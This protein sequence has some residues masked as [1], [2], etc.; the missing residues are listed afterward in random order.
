VQ[1]GQSGSPLAKSSR[2]IMVTSLHG[3]IGEQTHPTFSLQAQLLLVASTHNQPGWLSRYSNRIWAG[4]PGFGSR[5]G[6][7]IFR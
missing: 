4:G 1:A 5:Q 7:E 6:R 3:H 2:S